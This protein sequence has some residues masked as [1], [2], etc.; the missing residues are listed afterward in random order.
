MPMYSKEAHARGYFTIR[1]LIDNLERLAKLCGDGSR[2]HGKVTVHVGK[3]G[4]RWIQEYPHKVKG[5][6]AAAPKE[7]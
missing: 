4:E 5:P 6:D 3:G 7:H 2:I 1:E